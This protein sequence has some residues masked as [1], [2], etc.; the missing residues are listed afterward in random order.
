MSAID[1]KI[2]LN[3][4]EDFKSDKNIENL[5]S[6]SSKYGLIIG[7]TKKNLVLNS[8][9]TQNGKRYKCLSRGVK[10][11]WDEVK[12]VQDKLNRGKKKSKTIKEEFIDNDYS[13]EYLDTLPIVTINERKFYI[14][15]KKRERRLTERPNAVSKF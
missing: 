1:I 4:E 9:Y 14:D 15:T 2:P 7:V 5:I 3:E 13:Q 6:G 12:Q 10:I 11:S 8:Y